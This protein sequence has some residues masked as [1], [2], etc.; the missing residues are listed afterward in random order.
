VRLA[1]RWHLKQQACMHVMHADDATTPC[2]TGKRVRQRGGGGR[3]RPR[4][5]SSSRQ[6][7]QRRAQGQ[8]WSILASMH[9]NC[10]ALTPGS[11]RR[12]PRATTL[13][14]VTCSSLPTC[15]RFT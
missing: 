3:G 13:A 14:W 6:R 15:T 2:C 5:G 11:A 10:Q 12:R 9:A 1:M 7:G 8:G 4:R